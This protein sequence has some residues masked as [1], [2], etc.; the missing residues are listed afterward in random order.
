MFDGTLNECLPKTKNNTTRD[1]E[2]TPT[3]QKF[4]LSTEEAADYFNIGE[5]KLRKFAKEH[6]DEDCLLWC[7]N[8]LLFKRKKFE[9]YIEKMN[10]F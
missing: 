10:I 5:N 1:K 6:R 4:N 8:R 9:E 7:G 3:W 2:K